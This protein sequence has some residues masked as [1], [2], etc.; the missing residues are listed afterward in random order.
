MARESRSGKV[1]I[2]ARVYD[3]S[4]KYENKETAKKSAVTTNVTLYDN[5]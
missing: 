3:F 4:M 1:G 5:K 2:D